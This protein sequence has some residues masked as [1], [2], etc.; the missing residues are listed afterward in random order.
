MKTTSTATMSETDDKKDIIVPSKGNKMLDPVQITGLGTASMGG[1]K[2]RNNTGA[3]SDRQPVDTSGGIIGTN[4]APDTSGGILGTNKAPDYSLGTS[5]AADQ[6]KSVA[7]K[8]KEFFGAHMATTNVNAGKKTKTRSVK[9]DG[10]QTKLRPSI[11][12]ISAF[13]QM[14]EKTALGGVPQWTAY[15]TPNNSTTRKF[16]KGIGFSGAFP[17]MNYREWGS[18][19]KQFIGPDFTEE[20]DVI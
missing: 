17:I 5:L 7:Q 6:K 11:R 1:G 19:D 14:N 8:S 13:G 2:V 20:E 10:P 15:G 4:K 12:K 18:G 9:G 16:L 3:I